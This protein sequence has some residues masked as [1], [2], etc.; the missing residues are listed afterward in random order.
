MLKIR[1]GE[2]PSGAGVYLF[3]GPGGR[4]LYIG[5]A[6]N[7]KKRVSSYF[8]PELSNKTFHLMSAARRIEYIQTATENEAEVLEEKLIKL[9]RP[10]YNVL[11]TDDKSYPFICLTDEKY[12]RLEFSRGRKSANCFGPYPDS[13]SLRISLRNLKR[14]FLLP[15]CSM[16]QYSRIKKIA[17][18][19]RCVYFHLSKCSAP[20]CGRITVGEYAGRIKKAVEF[21]RGR[22]ISIVKNLQKEMKR[23]A[24]DLNFEKALRLKK[25]IEAFGNIVMRVDVAGVN[26]AKYLFNP[27]ASMR[28][29]K[30]VLGL[31]K[32][33][34]VI[35]GLD[36]SHTQGSFPT[37]SAVRFR[38]GLPDK[39]GYRKFSV[40]FE[41]IDDYAMLREVVR[42]RYKKDTADLILIDG[43]PGQV[44]SAVRALSESGLNP[45]VAGLAKREEIIYRRD[46][47]A[48]KLKS[49]SRGLMLLM[50][51]RDEAH[52]FALSY[53]RLRRSRI[54]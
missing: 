36:I 44:S 20:C 52:R 24:L 34:E 15:P 29:I 50:H 25:S 48:V 47:S 10:K 12:P 27:K 22:R 33:P 8:R 14:I 42:R 5:K 21:L 17:D 46:G 51:I 38:N 6:K 11:M 9:F 53:H 43:G 4:I 31:A 28:E 39:S 19:E 13:G 49:N 37:A 18:P 26:A 54:V 40:R 32:L 16:P 23:A 2:I 3:K 41:G 1:T 45:E 35:D 7:L 30:K